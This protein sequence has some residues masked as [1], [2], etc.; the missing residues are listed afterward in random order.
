MRGHADAVLVH[1]RSPRSVSAGGNGAAGHQVVLVGG[2]HQPAAEQRAGT[3]AA[4][5]STASTTAAASADGVQAHRRLGVEP[6]EPERHDG[7]RRQLRVLV[8]HAGQRV[9]EH[10]AVVDARAHHD[11]A[12]HL[13]AVVEQ[14]PQPAQARRR[15]AGSQHPGAHLGV[16]GVDADVQR[17]QA[18]GDHPLEVGLGEAGERGEVPVEEAQ[19]VVVVLE[20]QAAAQALAAAG[21]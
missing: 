8:E 2:E 12:V 6:A 13:D 19:P 14:G 16:G 11:L 7:H 15:R 20:V 18:L 1:R 17:R 9:V 3:S 21:R 10:R 4:S 5:A